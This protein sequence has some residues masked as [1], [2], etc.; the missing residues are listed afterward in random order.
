[1]FFN[2]KMNY[3]KFSLIDKFITFVTQKTIATLWYFSV[4]CSGGSEG[5]GF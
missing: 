3:G 5:I 2:A 4:L 1:L